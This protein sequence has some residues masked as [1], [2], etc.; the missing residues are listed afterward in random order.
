MRLLRII[1]QIAVALAVAGGVQVLPAE[2]GE[3]AVV[4]AEDDRRFAR[5]EVLKVPLRTDRPLQRQD[6]VGDVDPRRRV[7]RPRA[8][9]ELDHD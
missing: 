6:P 2:L 9:G 8:R 7:E 5:G 1:A 3:Q 4:V